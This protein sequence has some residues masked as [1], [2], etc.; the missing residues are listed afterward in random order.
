MKSRRIVTDASCPSLEVTE[1]VTTYASELAELEP[2]SQLEPS[3]SFC[4]G[5]WYLLDS[6]RITTIDQIQA[7]NICTKE[8]M[9][10]DVIG[11]DS[12]GNI[13]KPPVWYWLVAVIVMFWNLLG[14]F[15]FTIMVLMVTGT[16]DIA[17]EEAMAGLTEVQRS[18]NMTTKEVILSTPMWSNV[19]F[20]TAVGF[21]VAGSIALLMRRKVAVPIFVISLVGVLVQNSY[22]YLLSDAVEKM[23]VGLSPMVILVA[24][25]LVPFTLFCSNRRWLH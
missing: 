16:L 8:V 6:Y 9:T 20:A 1:V 12:T 23:G 11:I 2:D 25:A 5:V 3:R 17:S 24:V 18:Q 7:R 14:V 21:G 4:V 10:N 15:V 22:N 13:N 19:A